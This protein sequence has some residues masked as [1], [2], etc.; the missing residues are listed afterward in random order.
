MIQSKNITKKQCLSCAKKFMPTRGSVGKYCSQS[1]YRKTLKNGWMT[2]EI[3]EK[4]IETLI[5]NFDIK[6]RKTELNKAIRSSCQYS[7][8]R[9]EVFERDDYACVECNT[10]SGN[11]KAIT[12]NADHIKTFAIILRENNIDSLKRAKICKELWDIKNGRTL[13]VECHK[14]TDTFARKLN[15]SLC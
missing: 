10:R 1:C 6:G 15:K 5:K 7:N 3:N 11:G 13:C 4:R 14:Q 8:W 2:P 9:S 12:L